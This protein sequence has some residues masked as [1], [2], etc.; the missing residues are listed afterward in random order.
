MELWAW[1]ANNYGQLGDGHPCEQVEKPL[2]VVNVPT[3]GEKDRIVCG[4]GHTFLLN[5]DT[6]R[7]YA[8]GWNNKGQLGLKDQDNRSVFTLVE[9]LVDIVDIA[10]GWD[11]SL[12]L[13]KA[14]FVYGC[15][16]NAF[17]QLG[18]L[19]TDDKN[20]YCSS[21]K[22]LE[23]VKNVKNVACGLRHSLFLLND[24]SVAGCGSNRKGQLNLKTQ[25]EKQAKVE[26]VTIVPLEDSS[27][28]VSR[29]KAGQNFS[30]LEFENKLFAFGDD[31]HGQVS[32][33]ND[34]FCH[35]ENQEQ[36]LQVECGWTHVAI[37]TKNQSIKSWGR[38]DYGQLS[39]GNLTFNKV[40]SGYEHM[41]GLASNSRLYSWG[42]NEH[43]NCGVGHVEN[44]MTPTLVQGLNSDCRVVDCF[45][46]SGHSFALVKSET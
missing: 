42:W 23:D 35:K 16:S 14:G 3:L 1:G 5:V 7:V 24:G 6:G 29:V 45:A 20:K 40:S 41:L 26:L 13:D 39:H 44:V 4:G 19:K 33:I 36:V 25:P 9:N 10:A 32:G 38:K 43:G 22:I 15:G 28:R 46:G 18:S 12:A 37:L 30:V 17:G 27:S 8:T 21:F 11:F 2:K 31:K 34:Y